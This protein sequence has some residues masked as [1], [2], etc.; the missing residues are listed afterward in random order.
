MR[1][2]NAAVI[3]GKVRPAFLRTKR[4]LHPQPLPKQMRKGGRTCDRPGY[5]SSTC[6]EENAQTSGMEMKNNEASASIPTMWQGDTITIPCWMALVFE[7]NQP[8][9]SASIRF[10]VDYRPMILWPIPFVASAWKFIYKNGFSKEFRFITVK[11]G[12][13]NFRWI[14]EPID[15][16]PILRGW[17]D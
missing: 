14:A 8:Y 13:G 4:R 7:K 17:A 2:G 1:C 10:R 9:I 15:Y 12:D 6:I 3:T 5:Q 16:Q 11:Q